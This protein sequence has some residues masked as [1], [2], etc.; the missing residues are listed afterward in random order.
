MNTALNK[1]YIQKYLYKIF[2]Y[3]IRLT[4]ITYNYVYVHPV[5]HGCMCI[6]YL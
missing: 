2:I 6:V 1:Q 5:F 4:L 3:R